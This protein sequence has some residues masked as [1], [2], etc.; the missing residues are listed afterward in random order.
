LSSDLIEAKL[1]DVAKPFAAPIAGP[2]PAG[3]NARRDERHEAI[4]REVDKLG[5]P[6][7]KEV[8]WDLIHAAG[9]ALLTEK[10]KDYLIASYFGVAA[11]MRGGPQ[12]LVEGIVALCAL[13]E[14]YWDSGFPPPSRLRARVNAIDWFVER[15]GGLG[16]RAPK[17]VHPDDFQMLSRAAKRLEGLVLERFQEDTPN[18]YGLRQTLERI[19]LSIAAQAE[20]P[21]QPQPQPGSPVSAAPSAEVAP[22]PPRATG[23]PVDV[24]L[25]EIAAPFANPIPGGSRAGENAR[26]D[27]RHEAI[28][29]EVDKLGK[30]TAEQVSWQ[31][32]RGAGRDLLTTKSKDFLIACYFA[33]ASYAE[34]GVHGLVTGIAA[35]SAL[36]RD[37]WDDGFPPPK[38]VRARVAAIDWFVERVGSLED[39]APKTVQPDDFQMLSVAAKELEELVL[40]RFRDEIPNIHRL[41]ET[42]ERVEL[43]MTQQAPPPSPQPVSSDVQGEASQDPPRAAT[44]ATVQLAAPTVQLA[45]PAQVNKFL[46]EVG[47]SLHKASRALFKASKEDPL[48]Y[49]L[50]RQGLYMPFS[51]APPP[52]SG[53]QTVVP[54]P[55]PDR[56]PHL[57]ALLSSQNWAML[58]DEAESGLASARLWLDQHRYVAVALA[59]LGYEK[60]RET[61][62]GETVSLVQRLPGVL[63]RE[64]SDGQPFASRATKEW[65]KA[66]SPSATGSMAGGAS[67]GGGS[68]VFEQ[69]LAEAHQVAIGGNL[70]EAVKKLTEIV[71]S[72][73]VGGRDRF[74]AKLAMAD[75]C[76]VAG[77]PALAEGI[78]AALGSQIEQFRLEEWEPKMAEACYRSRYEALATM[79]GESA[80]SR[81]DLVDVYR[82]LCAVA[83]A[84]ALELGKPP[85]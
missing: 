72:E 52:E 62:V 16:D 49:R 73:A 77:A 57:S 82:R 23:G 61:V 8:D 37:Y 36:L 35:V 59:G 44:A 34:E 13:L 40:E 15:V 63:E 41:K 81:D 53:N 67:D 43:S 64:F 80:K 29:N 85:R 11:Y 25:A 27:E 4:R 30:P 65:L 75:A 20:Q 47:D 39:L 2:K 69:A 32:V 70:D 54:P 10:S 14:S 28:R 51:Q 19:E 55:P 7:A 9:L 22:S 66:A 79:A 46:K 18:I 31:L 50:C 5:R 42:L 1:A 26:H 84:A 48:A 17:T 6:E 24:R 33:A 38:R 78:L 60:A 45:D 68:G 83:P 58:L 21:Q 56:E 12:G 74:R 3:E 71:E 76:A